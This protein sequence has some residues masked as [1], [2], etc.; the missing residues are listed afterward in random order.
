MMDA[1]R[2]DLIYYL[3]EKDRYRSEEIY[4]DIMHISLQAF[5]CLFGI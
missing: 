2:C 5:T 3:A 1:S 4:C